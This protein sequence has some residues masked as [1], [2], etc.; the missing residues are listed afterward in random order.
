[1]SKENETLIES[2]TGKINKEPP[3]REEKNEEEDDVGKF[4][5]SIDKL[6][7][8][9]EHVPK[10]FALFLDADEGYQMGEI[11]KTGKETVKLRTKQ[12]K[13]FS[14][15]RRSI[16]LLSAEVVQLIKGEDAP[17]C[18]TNDDEAERKNL[19]YQLAPTN[20]IT[21]PPT[22]CENV[23]S[24]F[25]CT[26]RDD[27]NSTKF[28]RNVR[29]S[30]NFLVLSSRKK[31]ILLD[32]YVSLVE[33]Y[34]KTRIRYTNAYN[35]TRSIIAVLNILTPAFVSIMPLFENSNLM[36]TNTMYWVTFGTTVISGLTNA[37][38]RLFRLDRK[39]FSTN[40]AFLL[41]ETEGWHYL[42]LTGEYSAKTPDGNEPTH[43][44]KFSAF[45]H[46]VECIRRSEMKVDMAR[47]TNGTSTAAS[48]VQISSGMSS[49]I[50]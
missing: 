1:M 24:C 25:C 6:Y 20:D 37:F 45:C 14:V 48:S 42:T 30:I 46:E 47:P 32:R 36:Y 26:P 5:K 22:C 18:N 29:R 8:E 40:R 43:D 7:S 38:E 15:P 11:M 49:S 3:R 31:A 10:Q 17:S 27:L 16:Q 19:E 12:K 21:E 13:I 2:T 35:A 23:K 34:A 50:K 39:F 44:N 4:S 28:K 41:L 9:E 33:T